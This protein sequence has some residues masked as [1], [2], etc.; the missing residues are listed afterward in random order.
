MNFRNYAYLMRIETCFANSRNKFMIFM[1]R[2][3]P[4]VLEFGHAGVS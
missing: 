1:M 3:A 4:R 2:D